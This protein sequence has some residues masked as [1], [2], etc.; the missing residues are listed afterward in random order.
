[1]WTRLTLSQKGAIT[2][3]SENSIIGVAI[4]NPVSDS[5]IISILEFRFTTH[6]TCII[7]RCV[8]HKGGKK[9]APGKIGESSNRILVTIHAGV[10]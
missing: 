5:T 3:K 7:P 1:M 6:I 10:K 2:A 4:H 8:S 9:R